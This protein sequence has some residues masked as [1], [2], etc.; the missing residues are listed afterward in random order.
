[1]MR[2]DHAVA[3]GGNCLI[4]NH[5]LEREREKEKN[6]EREKRE[7][8]NEGE[9]KRREERE[10]KKEKRRKRREERER[11]KEKEKK[12]IYIYLLKNLFI[13]QGPKSRHCGVGTQQCQEGMNE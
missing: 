11:K 6:R 4:N 5:L 10:E 1:M 7:R 9:R 13:K 8:K 2:A 12:I 3:G